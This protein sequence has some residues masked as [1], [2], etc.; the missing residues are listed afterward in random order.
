MAD[1]VEAQMKKLKDREI[2]NLNSEL[3][4]MFDDVTPET[5][6]PNTLTPRALANAEEIKKLK[7]KLNRERLNV[8]V[9][10]DPALKRVGK[11][12][13][14]ITRL[15]KDTFVDITGKE[16]TAR[17]WLGPAVAEVGQPSAAEIKRIRDLEMG[18]ARKETSPLMI[19]SSGAATVWTRYKK[20]CLANSCR[21]KGY[22]CMMSFKPH[23]DN[24]VRN[25]IICQ[26][27]VKR[28]LRLC[29]GKSKNVWQGKK[30]RT[31]W[32]I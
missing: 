27:S 25:L 24:L 6:L 23:F 17:D 30:A 16:G 19:R 15:R 22:Q 10:G 4:A 11:L 20:S 21:K 14:K 12:Q 9:D 2:K 28:S 7:H 32:M 1:I 18:N 13:D 31:A 3:H 29:R 5:V 26:E 8:S